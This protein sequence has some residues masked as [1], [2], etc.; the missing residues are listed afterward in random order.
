[1]QEM[2]PAIEQQATP[3]T[4][5]ELV[6]KIQRGLAS[7][8]FLYGAIDGKAG[9]ATARAIRQFEIFSNL[10]VTGEI[11]PELVDLLQAAGATI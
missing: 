2:P 11:S 6:M 3:A 9:D 8:G 5:P 4:N 7:L 1:M 10:D